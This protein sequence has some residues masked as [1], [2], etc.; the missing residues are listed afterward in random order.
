MS[1]E[2]SHSSLTIHLNHVKK[3]Y[4]YYSH[5]ESPIYFEPF[6]LTGMG[7]IRL[8]TA[9]EYTILWRGSLARVCLKDKIVI[10]YGHLEIE[11]I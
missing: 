5:H 1:P 9:I 7:L 4:G 6:F 8:G 3:I 10:L 2:K 11:V